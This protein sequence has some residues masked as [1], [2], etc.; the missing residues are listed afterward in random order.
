MVSSD[1]DEIDTKALLKMINGLAKASSA[2]VARLNE[3]ETKLI[4]KDEALAKVESELETDRQIVA[5]LQGKV[6][7]RPGGG[8]DSERVLNEVRVDRTF[9]DDTSPK[10]LNAFLSHFK[11]VKD[12]NNRRGV[13]LWKDASY[14]AEALR[15]VL[16]DEVAEFVDTEDSMSSSWVNDDVMIIERLKERYLKAEC[17]EL[18]ILAFEE[19][20]QL[21]SGSLAAF[22]TRL[23]TLVKN[24][25]PRNPESIMRQRVIWRFLTGV[26]DADI[27]K[28]LISSKWMASQD[29]PKPYSEI[30]KAAESIQM[31]KVASQSLAGR[32]NQRTVAAVS[33]MSGGYEDRRSAEDRSTRRPTGW[34]TGSKRKAT[35][36]AA[37]GYSEAGRQSKGY[38]MKCYYCKELHEGGW[39]K[40]A[41]MKKNDPNWK[42]DF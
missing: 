34:S 36:A 32:G 7:A 13:V 4:V 35:V 41:K 39:Q 22:M 25:F 6:N 21:D 19:A 15:L 10:A 33:G 42:P 20:K 3:V 8:I 40:C 14:R 28:G 2:S 27:K 17:I 26:R 23:Q 29:E 5:D 37:G 18:N 30:L 31:T 38:V 9:G 12:Q 11:L 16:T 24:A 1:E